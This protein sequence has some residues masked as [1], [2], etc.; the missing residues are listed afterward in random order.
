MRRQACVTTNDAFHNKV[1]NRARDD[2][3]GR[4]QTRQDERKQRWNAQQ[5]RSTM[6]KDDSR[7]SRDLQASL[8]PQVAGTGNTCIGFRPASLLAC[9]CLL[10]LFSLLRFAGFAIRLDKKLSMLPALSTTLN[11]KSSGRTELSAPA[12]TTV[13]PAR[14]AGPKER[15]GTFFFAVNVPANET[16][17]HFVFRGSSMEHPLSGG[18]EV[19]PPSI[20]PSGAAGSGAAALRASGLQRQQEKTTVTLHI[21][22]PDGSKTPLQ[23]KLSDDVS[24][25]RALVTQMHD[26][27]DWTTQTDRREDRQDFS[28]WADEDTG[29][30]EVIALEKKPHEQAI[31][32]SSWR[33]PRTWLEWNDKRGKLRM[34]CGVY[35]LADGKS[36]SYYDIVDG[37]VI[38]P[39][40]ERCLCHCSH[41]PCRRVDGQLDWHV[42]DCRRTLR[43]C[44]C[45]CCCAT[46]TAIRWMREPRCCQIQTGIGSKGSKLEHSPTRPPHTS[47]IRHPISPPLVPEPCSLPLEF[48]RLRAF[49]LC[50]TH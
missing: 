29:F 35:H 39:L 7:T 16:E 31:A 12:S 50:C 14:R 20:E 2:Q 48:A 40:Y 45:D 5:T 41:A 47:D 49:G 37:S 26:T 34:M 44:H 32:P 8:S 18:V 15:N 6:I 38:H 25:L 42:C 46:G 19:A 10:S 21:V 30:A 1:R 13:R 24:T 36:L 11:K 9:A 17:S 27:A 3:R 28:D 4:A 33:N 43:V 22:G 23:I